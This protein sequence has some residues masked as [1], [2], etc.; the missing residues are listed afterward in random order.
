MARH[1]NVR[2]VL[3][4]V[5]V[6]TAL[7]LAATAATYQVVRIHD[8][9][10]A[11]IAASARASARAAARDRPSPAAASRPPL[12]RIR[13]VPRLAVLPRP[14]LPPIPKKYLRQAGR[15]AGRHAE[16]A[17]GSTESAQLGELAVLLRRSVTLR[18]LL[19]ATTRAVADCTLAPGQGLSRLD[20]VIAS[21]SELLAS[22]AAATVSQ[23]PGGSRLRAEFVS[24]LRFSLAADSEFADW[25]RTVAGESCPV[26]T[27]SVSS[28][29]AALSDSDLAD[30]AK[31]ELLLE[32]NP[33]AARS[34]EPVFGV[35]QI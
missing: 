17:A 9:T 21:R 14:S 23:V 3:L 18:S 25:L 34:G 27:L 12:T 22:V 11:A 16:S 8:R 30:A 4:P 33:L 31:A 35:G 5:C 10:A 28:F 2:G 1:G 26:P 20:R 7:L 19:N 24:A 15:T 32:W 29:L 6:I 13:P